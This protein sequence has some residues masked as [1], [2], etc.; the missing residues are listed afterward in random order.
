MK[1][2]I[3]L[4][5]AGVSRSACLLVLAGLAATLIATQM[6]ASGQD[7]KSTAQAA[8]PATGNPENGKKIFNTVGCFE[9]HDHEGQGGT[10]TGPRLAGDPITFS[11]FVSQL[12]HPASQMPPYTEKVLSDTQVADIYS[13]LHS[14][15]KPPPAS[16][17]PLLQE[18]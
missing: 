1:D 4:R 17:I 14:I 12:R 9:C 5:K 10:G 8:A 2:I 7:Q 3:C 11:A 18:K 13:Y 15:P 16:S 6:K